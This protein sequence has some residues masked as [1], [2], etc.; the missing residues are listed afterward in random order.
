MVIHKQEVNTNEV[1]QGDVLSP[2]M[3]SIYMDE[4]LKRLKQQ[5]FGCRI[6]NK[7]LGRF[8]YAD[9]LTLDCPSIHCLQKMIDI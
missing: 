9:I 8:S 5:S 3:F 1:K 6:G 7:F 4:L 2:I